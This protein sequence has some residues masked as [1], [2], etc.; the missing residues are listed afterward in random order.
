MGVWKLHQTESFNWAPRHEGVL[1]SGGIA[2]FIL[3]LGTRW[4]WVVSFTPRKEP[5]IPTGKESGWAPE[6]VWTR[7]WKEK[8]PAPAGTQIPDH[9]ARSSELYQRAIRAPKPF[10]EIAKYNTDYFLW[11]NCITH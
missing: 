2:P 9:P 6:P 3:G 5:L 11:S 10:N 4:R 7:W 8:F 1:G